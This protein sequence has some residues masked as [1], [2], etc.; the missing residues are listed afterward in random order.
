MVVRK[1]A[2]L[3]SEAILNEKVK[4]AARKNGDKTK[5]KSSP[6][7]PKGILT[8]MI[9]GFLIPIL[10]I[11][12]LGSISFK[13][14]S[15]TLA[16]NYKQSATET[17]DAIGL[18]FNL[19]LE[20][21]AAKSLEIINDSKVVTYYTK[22]NGLKENENS[23]LYRDIKSYLVAAKS[24]I[25]GIDAIHIFGE[26]EAA[27]VG[28]SSN[29]SVSGKT[30]TQYDYY[31]VMPHST[32]GELD[33]NTYSEFMASQEG[34]MWEN[35][36]KKDAWIGT[37]DFLDKKLGKDNSSYAVSYMRKLSK[38]NGFI[39]MDVKLSAITSILERMNLGD[40]SIVA[41][42]TG[43][44]REI[45]ASQS[46]ISFISFPFYEE[47]KQS[48]GSTGFKEVELNGEQHYF[49][50]AKIGNTGAV[51]CGLI[52]RNAVFAQVNKIRNITFLVVF[53]ASILALL[54]GAVISTSINRGIK[55]ISGSLSAAAKGDLTVELKVKRKDEFGLLAE[56]FNN[57]LEGIK[58]LLIQ[59]AEIGAKVRDSS[60]NVA[61]NSESIFESMKN[62]CASIDEIQKGTTQQVSDTESCVMQ[63][64]SLSDRISQVYDS[65]QKIG[66]IADSSQNVI[67]RGIVIVDDLNN[68]TKATTDITKVVIEGIEALE[69]QSNSIY[70]IISVIN[71]IAAQTNLLS[72]NASIEA[73]RAGEAGKGF[74]VV[75]DE[76]RKLAEQSMG[77]VKQIKSIIDNIQ[78]MTA[79]TAASAKEAETNVALQIEALDN[80]IQIFNEI[81]TYVENLT[82]DLG[83]ITEGIEEIERTKHDTLEAVQN[84]SSVTQQSAAASEEVNAT[85]TEQM[86]IIRKMSEEAV[87]LANDA[88]S[89]E[90][91]ISRFKIEARL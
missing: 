91:S 38:G 66:H 21:I 2:K 22:S 27:K 16:E 55:K 10:L 37:H 42:I 70:G 56:N 18:Y 82:E 87:V 36:S 29:S 8:K 64:N 35:I 24:S 58:K 39:V 50:F 44:G 43:D 40:D 1:K 32:S 15:E 75:A 53:I 28:E 14:A 34:S 5:I 83:R 23:V 63:M 20:N 46:E 61:S 60:G 26:G 4:P 31:T 77:A 12:F 13:N 30:E 78:S 57:M 86:D 49:T 85:V 3:Q 84:I 52:P 17:M 47:A 74:A 88:K 89:L 6:K 45:K 79:A 33:K 69:K 25:Q 76:I 51:V 54:T 62:I 80:T 11:I 68:K 7:N 9:I 67:K 41:F 90:E 71:G 81:S 65:V 72:L 59:A 48:G 73:A 19:T